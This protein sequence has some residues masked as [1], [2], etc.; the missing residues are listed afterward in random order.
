MSPRK[1]KTYLGLHVKFPVF[2]K[3]LRKSGFSP[4]I[5]MEVSNKNFH[6]N[7]CSGNRAVTCG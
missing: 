3:D 1:N 6:E 2:L 4:Q 7:P 5:T